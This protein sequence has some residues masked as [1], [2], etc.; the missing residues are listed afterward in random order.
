MH[1]VCPVASDEMTAIYERAQR[2]GMSQERDSHESKWTEARSNLASGN[3]T[4]DCQLWTVLLLHIGLLA[5]VEFDIRLIEQSDQERKREAAGRR[6][7][8]AE[9]RVPAVQVALQIHLL[10]LELP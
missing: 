10:I 5:V 1:A 3:L 9:R 4:A 2:V 8:E 7:G 6:L